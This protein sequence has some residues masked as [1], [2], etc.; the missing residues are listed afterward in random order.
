MSPV[1]RLNTIINT[2]QC[3]KK[4]LNGQKCYLQTPIYDYRKNSIW[5]ILR[6]YLINTKNLSR[7]ESFKRIKEWLDRCNSLKPLEFNPDYL[8]QYK[9]NN[10]CFLVY[11]V[12]VLQ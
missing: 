6:P 1:K 7:D 3:Q 12:Y 5:R 9:L 11:A 4:K 10:G 8:I 2:T